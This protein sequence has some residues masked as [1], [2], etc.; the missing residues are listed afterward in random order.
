MITP[1]LGVGLAGYFSPRPN[2][3]VLD[4]LFVR[5]CLFRQDG[6]TTGLVQWD[7]LESTS[8][9]VDEL[10]SQLAEVEIDYADDLVIGATHTHTAPEVRLARDAAHHFGLDFVLRQTVAAVQSAEMSLAPS[11]ISVST[12]VC[13]PFAFNRRFWMKD[14]TVIT[15]P[16]K[17]NPDIERPEG[18]VDRE[19]TVL[20][21]TQGG[22]LA[23]L[24]AN[25]VNHT[26]TI[27]GDLVSADWPGFL[28]RETSRR[29]GWQVPVLTLVGAS[30]NIN[31][32]D[33]TSELD[34]ASYEESRTIG[35]GYARIVAQAMEA[36]AS[37][38]EGAL[39]SASM[40]LPFHKREIS[41]EVLARAKAVMAEGEPEEGVFTSEDLAK[42]APGVLRY[43]AQQLIQY[44]AEEAGTIIPFRLSAI[45]FGNDLAI[46]S[47]PG[48]P[49]TEIG[50]AIK[51]ASPFATTLVVTNANGYAG[52]VCM[53][54]CYERGGYEPLPVEHGGGGPDMAPAMIQAAT[55]LLTSL[56]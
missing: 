56:A 51:Q 38:C 11:R 9:M 36:E 47:L 30:G 31:H 29:L 5:V 48:E 26:D 10:R 13:N 4:D 50:Q 25:I 12:V 52:Y 14:G 22:R 37:P 40:E 42:G 27:G 24:L 1:P 19:I 39:R 23:G 16:G 55:D 45:A 2:T 21:I 35:E 32:F 41:P 33:V 8:W 17:R 6:H 7:L 18:D 34:Q 44:A 53:P 49:F 28:E 20:R 3:G 15:N 43:F 54:E 46:V